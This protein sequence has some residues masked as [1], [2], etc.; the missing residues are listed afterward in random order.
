[1]MTRLIR[2]ENEN[3]IESSSVTIEVDYTDEQED[4]VAFHIDL[5]NM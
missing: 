3:N 5:H 2:M 4:L 1:M